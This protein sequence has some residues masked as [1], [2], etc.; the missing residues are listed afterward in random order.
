MRA[1]TTLLALTLIPFISCA[2]RDID[3]GFSPEGGAQSLVLKTINN[4]KKSIRMM[5]FSFSAPDVMKALVDAQQRG[6]DVRAVI[7]EEGNTRAKS[8]SAMRYITQHG[9]RLRTDNHYRIQHDKVIIV[10]DD[11]V[12]TG[13][14]NFAKSSE[15]LN[16][17]NVIVIHRAPE[18]AKHYLAHWENRWQQGVDFSQ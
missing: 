18:L 3:V 11:T 6:V 2:S 16:S 8:L 7:D 12:E 5:A 13:S 9:V 10:D 1:I 15:Y 4:A 14:F 17:E